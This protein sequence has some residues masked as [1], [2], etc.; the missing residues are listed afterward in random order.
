MA[1]GLHNVS[2]EVAPAKRFRLRSKTKETHPQGVSS[3]Y[4]P[5]PEPRAVDLEVVGVNSTGKRTIT[6]S[7]FL[8]SLSKQIHPSHPL[9]H[10]RGV[11]WCWRCGSFASKSIVKLGIACTGGA[12]R[13]GLACLSRLRRGLT[14][15]SPRDWPDG[16][17]FADSPPDLAIIGA[18]NAPFPSNASQGNVNLPSRVGERRRVSRDAAD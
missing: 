17:G 15:R 10:K 3:A 16:G 5:Q 1:L 18:D 8:A 2:E 11:V 7:P 9:G 4:A 12:D 13:Y 6:I 14:P